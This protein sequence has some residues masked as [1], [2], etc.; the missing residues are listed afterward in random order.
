MP[1]FDLVVRNVF[2][3]D[4]TRIREY[5]TDQYRPIYGLVIFNTCVSSAMYNIRKLFGLLTNIY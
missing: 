5:T 2:L 1:C 3:V 4:D